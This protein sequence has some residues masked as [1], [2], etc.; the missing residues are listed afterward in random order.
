MNASVENIRMLELESE[1]GIIKLGAP[2]WKA[3]VLS[4][5]RLARG[6]KSEASRFWNRHRAEI[7]SLKD[8]NN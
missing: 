3:V 5:F 2:K 7:V 6:L 4:H 8:C 1:I